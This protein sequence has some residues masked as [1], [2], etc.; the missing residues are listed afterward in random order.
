MPT[1]D[2]IG[3]DPALFKIAQICDN[4]DAFFI[5]LD[6][7]EELWNLDDDHGYNP[8]RKWNGFCSFSIAVCS[9]RDG[10]YSCLNVFTRQMVDI[11]FRRIG[12][13]LVENPNVKRVFFPINVDTY[14]IDTS[15]HPFLGDDVVQYIMRKMHELVLHNSHLVL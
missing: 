11:G 5:Y 9:K 10:C 13:A 14:T 2:V 3:V 1:V 8:M 12:E 4:P 6:V 7:D 15:A